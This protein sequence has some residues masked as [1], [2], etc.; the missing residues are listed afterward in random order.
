MGETLQW[1]RHFLMPMSNEH[2][3]P[4]VTEAMII[5]RTDDLFHGFKCGFEMALW[6]Q[7]GFIEYTCRNL[8]ERERKKA[9]GQ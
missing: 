6:K 4:S 8:T 2:R 1:K 3:E 5:K 7:V 9:S